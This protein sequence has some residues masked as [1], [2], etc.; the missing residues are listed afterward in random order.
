MS[1]ELKQGIDREKALS[2]MRR[3]LSKPMTIIRGFFSKADVRR[4]ADTD[5]GFEH[6]DD[7][8]KALRV[9]RDQLGKPVRIGLG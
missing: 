2:V 9:M 8:D 4:T 7:K 3:Q 6:T 5:H 1:T